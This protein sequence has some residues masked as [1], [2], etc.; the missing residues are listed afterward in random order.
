M[1]KEDS[2]SIKRTHESIEDNQDQEQEV[3]DN[4]TL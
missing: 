1:H 4:E 3:Q 2:S